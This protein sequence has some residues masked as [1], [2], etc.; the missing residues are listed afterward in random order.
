[1][2]RVSNRTGK[3]REVRITSAGDDDHIQILDG[4]LFDRLHGSTSNVVG[5]TSAHGHQELAA[6]G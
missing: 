4:N 1:M 3:G 5:V 2:L 6:Y